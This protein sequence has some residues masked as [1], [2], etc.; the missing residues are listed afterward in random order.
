[1]EKLLYIEHKNRDLKGK[2]GKECIAALLVSLSV[3]ICFRDLFSLRGFLA[4]IGTPGGGLICI[5]NQIVKA[6]G[7]S[8]Y[9]LLDVRAGASTGCGLFAILCLLVLALAAFLL[10]RTGYLWTMLVFVLP[11][12]FLDIFFQVS[13]SLAAGGFLFG[14]ILFALCCMRQEIGGGMLHFLF[15]AVILALTVSLTWVGGV[16]CL[17]QK[18]AAVQQVNAAVKQHL[19]DGYYGTNPLG[20]GDLT[21]RKRQGGSDTALEIAMQRPHSM[22]LRGFVGEQ[23]DGKR[24]KHLP[25]GTYYQAENLMYWLSQSGCTPMGQVR[26]AAMLT[27][28]ESPQGEIQ[29]EVQDADRRYAYIPYEICDPILE[30]G[31]AWGG[32]FISAPVLGRLSS[33]SYE[34]GDNVVKD[35][36]CLLYT[37]FPKYAS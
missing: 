17:T 4:G 34:A 18:P 6:L 37:S 23:F 5:W 8:D 14:A 24:W 21:Q 16:S 32:S 36:T 1:M 15:A 27:G 2:T 7:S 22:Y 29:I 33:Y 30:E 11:I 26:D 9:V 35:W 20:S 12:C 25:A 19:S 13:L 3:C 28:N 31:R 10:I